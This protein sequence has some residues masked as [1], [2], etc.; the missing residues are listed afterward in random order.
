MDSVVFFKNKT[1]LDKTYKTKQAQIKTQKETNNTT[2]H[3]NKTNTKTKHL[4][5]QQR[6]ILCFYLFSES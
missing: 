4:A 2:Q 3:K 1:K 5:S 6:G